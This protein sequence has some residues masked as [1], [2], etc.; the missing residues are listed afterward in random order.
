MKKNFEISKF[1][2]SY[3]PFCYETTFASRCTY[4]QLRVSQSLWL[5]LS[6]SIL[7]IFSYPLKRGCKQIYSPFSYGNHG[8]LFWRFVGE[9]FHPLPMDADVF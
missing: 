3:M 7:N 9:G 1:F 5:W 4:V 8:F 2:F 6:L